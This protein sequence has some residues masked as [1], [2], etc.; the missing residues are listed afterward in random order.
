MLLYQN[1]EE[2]LTGELEFLLLFVCRQISNLCYFGLSL[3]NLAYPILKNCGYLWK[4]T[5]LIKLLYSHELI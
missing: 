4:D 1:T 5:L 2:C 3:D